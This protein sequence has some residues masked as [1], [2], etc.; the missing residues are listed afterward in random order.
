MDVVPTEGHT[1]DSTTST[2]ER[3]SNSR[4]RVE[5]DEGSLRLDA[6]SG[7]LPRDEKFPCLEINL[8]ATRLS[9]QLPRF[10]SWRPDPLAEATDAFLQ[11]WRPVRGYANPP[12]NLIWEY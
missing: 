12:W 7:D 10:Y 2:G 8:F 11:D 1:S 5:S 4:Q 6:Q 9:H 3:D